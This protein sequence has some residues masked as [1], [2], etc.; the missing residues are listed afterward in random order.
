MSA[1]LSEIVENIKLGRE[2]ALVGNYESSTV[3]YQ[4]VLQQINRLV[5]SISDHARIHQWQEVST[6]HS[7]M[8]WHRLR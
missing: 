4:G 6:I 7:N 3:Y 8:T 1:T 5:G 2:F